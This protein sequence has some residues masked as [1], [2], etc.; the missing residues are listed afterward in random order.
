MKPTATPTPSSRQPWLRWHPPTEAKVL[1]L[2]LGTILVSELAMRSVESRLSRDI[3]HLQQF[4]KIV[5]RLDSQKSQNT[6]TVLVVGNSLVREGIQPETFRKTTVDQIRTPVAIERLHPDSTAFAEWYYAIDRFVLAEH[7][8]PNA[9]VLVFQGGHLR[10][11]PTHHVNELGR[12]YCGPEQ[13]PDLARFDLRTL[14]PWLQFYVCSVSSSLTNHERVE[15]R[16]LNSLVPN[17][18]DGIQELN[19][20]SQRQIAKADEVVS[21][22]R[23]S[24]LI[25]MLQS[26]QIAIVLVEIP[27]QNPTPIDPELAQLAIEKDI[28]LV[29][30]S[31]VATLTRDDFTDGLHMNASAAERYSQEL[32]I[33]IDWRRVFLKLSLPTPSL[34]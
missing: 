8:S 22:H 14:E 3:E 13:L 26:R 33:A 16:V 18:R 5:A 20:R 17:Y 31:Q 30:S 15:R 9:I 4:K 24:K 21:Y 32:A 6:H 11:A 10:D 34:N 28:L 29:K 1:G 25:Q 7:L 12:Y 27:I 19:R 23:L 2:V